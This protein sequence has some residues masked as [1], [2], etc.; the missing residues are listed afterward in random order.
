[1]K[2]TLYVNTKQWAGNQRHD[3]FRLLCHFAFFLI[4]TTCMPDFNVFIESEEM[5]V[6]QAKSELN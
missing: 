1:M 4:I 3:Y 6:V 2:F 5:E